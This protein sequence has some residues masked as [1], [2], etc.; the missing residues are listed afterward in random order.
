MARKTADLAQGHRVPRVEEP[1]LLVAVLEIP[2]GHDLLAT[3]CVEEL[4]GQTEL[5]EL[6]GCPLT[7]LVGIGQAYNENFQGGE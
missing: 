6:S 5:P 3:H 2:L 1:L 4:E 7:A